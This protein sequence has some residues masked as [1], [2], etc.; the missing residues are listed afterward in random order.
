MV[1]YESPDDDVLIYCLAGFNGLSLA[2]FLVLLNGRSY[3]S[4]ELV[5][6][7]CGVISHFFTSFLFSDN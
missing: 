2:E 4:M 6:D 3:L 1:P 7:D 5:L